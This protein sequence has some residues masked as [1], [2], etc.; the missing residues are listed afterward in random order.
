MNTVI[1]TTTSLPS[2][3]AGSLV[4]CLHRSDRVK[5]DLIDLVSLEGDNLT[6]LRFEKVLATVEQDLRSALD[7]GRLESDH[8]LTIGEQAEAAVRAALGGYLPSGFGIGHGFVYDAYGDGS[9]QTDV[10]IT[11]PDH[12][13]SF[14]EDR[15]GTYVVD[16]VSAAAK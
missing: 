7:K 16:G 15:S 14:P 8:S 12:P 1:S 2:V 11:N 4:E 6:G 13:L 9:R 3:G 10:I 5:Q